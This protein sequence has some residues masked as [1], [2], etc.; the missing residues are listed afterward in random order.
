MLRYLPV[1]LI[2]S[3]ILALN[4][5]V[6]EKRTFNRGYHVSWNKQ[7][8]RTTPTEGMVKDELI[9]NE[10]KQTPVSDEE[11]KFEPL[12]AG[13]HE[14]STA[15]DQDLNFEPLESFEPLNI[16]LPEASTPDTVYIYPK[17]EP[18]GI[19]SFATSL[20]AYGAFFIGIFFWEMLI[21]VSLGLL[22]LGLVFGLL[23]LTEYSRNKIFYKKNVFGIIGTCLTAAP[24]LFWLFVL[25]I[26]EFF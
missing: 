6:I 9:W 3:F 17:F 22:V 13:T 15:V 10:I 19:A 7:L 5:C 2:L 11:L 21:Y 24:I 14:K 1:I 16:E 8:R 23:S 18:L 20:S 26:E 25:L 12:K 4:S